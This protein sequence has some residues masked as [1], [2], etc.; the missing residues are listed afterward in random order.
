M[1]S[2]PKTHLFLGK[3]A[4]S[5]AEDIPPPREYGKGWQKRKQEHQLIHKLIH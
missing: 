3:S 4:S 1:N 2:L 5:E